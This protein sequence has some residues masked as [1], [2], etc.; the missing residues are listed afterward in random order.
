MLI[1]DLGPTFVKFGQILADRPD[2]L[3]ERIRSELKKLQSQVV[4]FDNNTAINLIENELG[5]KT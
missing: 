3:S 4:P 1:E 5:R 2:V